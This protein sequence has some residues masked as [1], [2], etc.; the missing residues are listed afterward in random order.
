[1]NDL[2]KL[3][4]FVEIA[5]S[6]GLNQMNVNIWNIY[7]CEYMAL[8]LRKQGFK[9]RVVSRTETDVNKLNVSWD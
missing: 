4:S 9:T 8:L 2:E 6:K 3:L 5:K 7:A 1:M